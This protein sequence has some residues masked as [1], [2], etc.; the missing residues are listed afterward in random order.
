MTCSPTDV[1]ADAAIAVD[2][3]THRFQTLEALHDVSLAIP[4]GAMFGLIGHNGA[5]KSTLFRLMLGL[6]VPTHGSVRV[7]GQATAAAAFRQA[8]RRIGYLPENFVTYDNLRG[9]EVLRLFADLKGVPRAECAG[10]L[11]RVGLDAAAATRPVHTYSKGMRQRLGL[12]QALLGEPA[13]LF[14]D[15]PTNG[16]DPRGIADFYAILAAAK[17]GGTTIVITSHI[18]AEIQER[19]DDLAIL[20]A[21]RVVAHGTLPQLRTAVALPLRIDATVAPERRAAT[22]AALLLLAARTD[23]GLTWDEASGRVTVRCPAAAKMAVL[24]ALVPHAADVAVH[25]ST[26]EQV[27]LG[28]GARH[29]EHV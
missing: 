22:V 28:Y 25:E 2:G 23:N 16:L 8:R 13:L 21:G 26:L 19:V 4:R 29:V 5:G 9:N 10:L 15:E 6:I 20:Q 12:A 24:A 17:A 1:P 18:L 11:E 7:L 14:L 27:F 3:V